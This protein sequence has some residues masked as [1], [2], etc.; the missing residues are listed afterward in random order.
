MQNIRIKVAAT[1]AQLKA[2][3]FEPFQIHASLATLNK[4]VAGKAFPH[5]SSIVISEDYYNSEHKSQVID[6]TVPHE[7]VHLY[8]AK[9][10]PLAKMVHGKEFKDLMRQLGCEDTTYHSMQLEGMQKRRNSVL[11]FVY[12]TPSGKEGNLTR[13]QHAKVLE[14]KSTFSFEGE[15]F[16]YTTKQIRV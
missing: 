13:Q 16:S 7:V 15:K 2:L 14:G 5:Q 1:I 11:R 3:G 12:T 10:F 4:G 9:Y 6:R 8:V